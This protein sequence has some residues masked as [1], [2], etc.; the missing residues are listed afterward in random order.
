ME[1]DW[2]TSKK[3]FNLNCLTILH[4]SYGHSDIIVFYIYI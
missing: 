2:A 4:I 3:L 1:T